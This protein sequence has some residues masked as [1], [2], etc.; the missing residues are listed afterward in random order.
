MISKSTVICVDQKYVS[1]IEIPFP[2]VCK[3]KLFLRSV[4]W[5]FDMIIRNTYMLHDRFRFD[6]QVVFRSDVKYKFTWNGYSAQCSFLFQFSVSFLWFIDKRNIVL[7]MVYVCVCN[8]CMNVW[9]WLWTWFKGND[10]IN[11]IHSMQGQHLDY[12]NCY[13]FL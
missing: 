7:V 6:R 3:E 1:S 12:N 5:N 10:W 4:V 13:V 9:H 2:S 8:I 11:I